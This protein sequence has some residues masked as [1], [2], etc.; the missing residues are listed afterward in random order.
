MQSSPPKTAPRSSL[1]KNALCS[2]E[3]CSTLLAA[4]K[5]KL[6]PDKTWVEFHFEL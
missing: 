5:R 1:P 2:T 4:E 3:N 6:L